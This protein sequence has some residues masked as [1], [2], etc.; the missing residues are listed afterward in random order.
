VN[1][2]HISIQID[3]SV[4]YFMKQYQSSQSSCQTQKKSGIPKISLLLIAS[5]GRQSIDNAR[6][7]DRS[8]SCSLY[9]SDSGFSP[10]IYCMGFE[11]PGPGTHLPPQGKYV[12]SISLSPIL[13]LRNQ[14]PADLDSDQCTRGQATENNRSAREASAVDSRSSALL[15]PEIFVS[16][17]R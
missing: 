12:P 6:S 10:R 4:F 3:F 14:K 1:A 13:S 17:P 9:R 8:T 7:P 15:G 2:F 11:E 16:L 5:S